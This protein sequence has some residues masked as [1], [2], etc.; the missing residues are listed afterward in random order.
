MR[1]RALF[2][3][4]YLMAVVPEPHVVPGLMREDF[5]AAGM[6]REAEGSRPQGRAAEAVPLVCVDD[7]VHEVSPDPV[8]QGVHPVH[9]AIPRI[10]E[11]RDILTGE[12]SLDVRHLLTGHQS[13]AVAHPADRIG[14]VGLGDHQVDQRLDSGGAAGRPAR[15]GCVDDRDVDG[16]VPGRFAQPSIELEGRQPVPPRGRDA[17]L[18]H[19]DVQVP[20]LQL[21]QGGREPPRQTPVVA[22]VQF[23]EVAQVSQ[24]G[25]DRTAQ[26][27]VFEGQPREVREVTQL[28]RDW[29]AQRVPPERQPGEVREVT[30]LGRDRAAQ[31]VVFKGERREVG[32]VSQLDGD[33]PAQRVPPERQPPEVDQVPQPRRNPAAQVVAIEAQSLQVHQASQRGRNRAA[34]LVRAEVQPSEVHQAAY[35]PPRNRAA[36]RVGAEIQRRDPPVDV[37]RHPVPV[38]QRRR[39]LPVRAVPPARAARRVVEQLQ[40]VALALR[41][42]ARDRCHRQLLSRAQAVRITRRHCHHGGPRGSR[43]E[44]DDVTRHDDGDRPLVARRGC[45]GQRIAVR[46]A[47]EGRYGQ[48]ACGARFGQR[49]RR[50][51]ADGHRRTIAHG[52]IKFD[53]REPRLKRDV[54]GGYAQQRVC[55]IEQH[56]S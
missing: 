5:A 44:P 7:Q 35:Q 15:G 1:P 40:H 21:P 36:Q 3:V 27:V 29:A 52:S 32:E 30:Q 39:R 33:W 46:V 42:G 9:M 10:R 28:G 24:L 56:E 45:V 6:D 34:Q 11:T 31:H 14:L 55:D 22:H 37:G 23:P 19:E 16:H 4:V 54:V 26:R 17:R 2:V 41:T 49:L 51:R 43:H 50:Y 8:A 13:Q 38:V 48:T 53:V 47:E 25:R 18:R 12:A 20:E